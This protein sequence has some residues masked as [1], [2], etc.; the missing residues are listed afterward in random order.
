MALVSTLAASA[1]DRARRRFY[2]L[3]GPWYRCRLFEAFGSTRYSRPALFGMDE[4]LTEL[5]PWD[6]GTFVEAGAHDGYTQSN[7]YYLERH[8]N[9][10][11]ALVEPIPELC[12]LCERR[13]PRSHVVGCALVGP[14]F[15]RETAEVQFGDL[16]SVV[17]NA[18]SHACGG[19]A[20]A[21]RRGYTVE[22]PARTLSDVLTDADYSRIDLMVLD[23]EGREL[24]VLAGLDFG[25]HAPRYLL[26]EALN[27]EAH[28]P[29][30]DC[31]L[32]A[33][34]DFVDALSEYDLL[35]RRRD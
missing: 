31:V 6:G 30:L 33:H 15:G 35:Y 28:Q 8:R 22:V 17:G 1:M 26:V 24:E 4:K 7:T 2:N 14:D 3:G 23:V 34:Y 29:A 11:G 16:M 5:M 27:R 32:A 10:S 19:L 13:R 9:W 18:G 12:E 21:G 25:R 20:V